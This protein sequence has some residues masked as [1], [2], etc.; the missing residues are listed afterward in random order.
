L[1]RTNTRARLNGILRRAFAQEV[2][3]S[4]IVLGLGIGEIRGGIAEHFARD[5]GIGLERSGDAVEV[6]E[7]QRHEGV[8]HE[9]RVGG[10]G[11]IVAMHRGEAAE[12]LVGARLVRLDAIAV[13]VDA[14]ELPD[15]A[16][17]AL[18]GGE[19]ELHDC[20]LGLAL[21]Q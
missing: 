18:L 21:A 20:L 1:A 11:A 5:I 16:G 8:G 6:V 2:E 10:A 15:G 17:N 12:I 4:E 9:P 7:P 14:A 3:P 19:F 13:R